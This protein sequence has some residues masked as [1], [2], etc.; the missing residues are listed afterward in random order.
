MRCVFP[1]AGFLSQTETVAVEI[2]EMNSAIGKLKLHD[3]NTGRQ[4]LAENNRD[5]ILIG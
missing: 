5:W 4:M 2:Q 3:A 1:A